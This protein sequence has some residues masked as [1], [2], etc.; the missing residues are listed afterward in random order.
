MSEID[1]SLL[2]EAGLRVGL[3]FGCDTPDV[4]AD[5][6]IQLRQQVA[7]LLAENKW[8][9]VVDELPNNPGWVIAED[10]RGEVYPCIYEDGQW[11]NDVQDELPT[12]VEIVRWR[13]LPKRKRGQNEKEN[14]RS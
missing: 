10:N 9:E 14:K 1:D 7:W 13:E 4:M 11:L 8:T 2:R 5:T 12:G 3:Y 6:I